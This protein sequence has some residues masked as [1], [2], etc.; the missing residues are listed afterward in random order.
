M[1]RLF[2]LIGSIVIAISFVFSADAALN[3]NEDGTITDT[4]TNLMWLQDFNLASNPDNHFGVSGIFYD[5]TGTFTSG[6]MA[7]PTANEW[8]SAMN[9]ATYLG[10]NDWRLPYSDTNCGSYGVGYDCTNSEMGHLY[11]DELGGIA[12][13]DLSSFSPFLNVAPE[14]YWSGTLASDQQ[15]PYIFWFKDLC[16]SYDGI[17]ST[18]YS[19]NGFYVTAVRDIAVVPEPISSILFITGGTLLAGRRYLRRKK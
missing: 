4:D 1:K 14:R 15:S 18:S 7:W 16:C 17:Q 11:Y 3:N 19:G 5:E 13:S 2:V 8:I 12:Q 10:Y 6:S 9:A